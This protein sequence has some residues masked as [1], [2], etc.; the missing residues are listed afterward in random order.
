MDAGNWQKLEKVMNSPPTPLLEREGN[1][2]GELV[3][4]AQKPCASDAI[5]GFR[6]TFIPPLLK[7]EGD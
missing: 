6:L 1:K 4:I 7:R 2:R 5:K 3:E